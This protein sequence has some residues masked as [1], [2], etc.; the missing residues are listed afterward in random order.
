MLAS[1]DFQVDDTYLEVHL[2]KKA[3]KYLIGGL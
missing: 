1:Q 2:F 3:K